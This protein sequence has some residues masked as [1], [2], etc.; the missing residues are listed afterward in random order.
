MTFMLMIGTG[1]VLGA[2]CI[3]Q[4]RLA[5]YTPGQVTRGLLWAEGV[6]GISNVICFQLSELK[7]LDK[8]NGPHISSLLTFIV[9]LLAPFV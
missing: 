7:I 1:I 3:F 8:R 9:F 6:V 5:N 2:L 4:M